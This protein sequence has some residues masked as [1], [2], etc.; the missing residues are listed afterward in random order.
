ML[1]MSEKKDCLRLSVEASDP[2]TFHW[3][4]LTVLYEGI[5]TLKTAKGQLHPNMEIQSLSPHADGI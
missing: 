2:A 3:A 1:Q 5:L 4:C